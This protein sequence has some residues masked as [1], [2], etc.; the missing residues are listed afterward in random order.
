[1]AQDVWRE[2]RATKFTVSFSKR[3][4]VGGGNGGDAASGGGEGSRLGSPNLFRASAS[5][6]L[7]EMVVEYTR[8]ALDRDIALAYAL[9]VHKAQG[10]EYPVVVVPVVPQ[11][12][13]MLYRNLIYTGVSRAKRL[14][15]LVGS[16]DALRK[17]VANGASARR[18]T[19]LAERVDDREFAPKLTQHMSDD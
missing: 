6:G 9:T 4:A 16:E 8:T 11:H 3:A 15:V 1:M 17:A 12:S 2:G 14:L 13:M 19:L 5:G 7:S 18:V 10:A